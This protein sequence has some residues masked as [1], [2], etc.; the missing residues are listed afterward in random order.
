MRYR[1]TA[2]GL[3]V[4]DRAP[5]RGVLGARRWFTPGGGG[6]GGSPVNVTRF[7]SGQLSLSGGSVDYTIGSVSAGDLVLVGVQGFLNVSTATPTVTADG[8]GNTATA[9]VTV[10]Q[11]FIDATYGSADIVELAI[12]GGGTLVVKLSQGGGESAV[13]IVGTQWGGATYTYDTGGV[14]SPNG[15]TQGNFLD[16]Y[17][18]SLTIA[19]NRLVM[20][21][22]GGGGVVAVSSG[23]ATPD[24]GW[25]S[26]AG[27]GAAVPLTVVDKLVST[28]TQPHVVYGSFAY[29]CGLC[30]AYSY[31]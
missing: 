16:M 6:G 20:A 29:G 2:S 12:T 24:A 30:V 3:W 4:P 1:R 5:R 23:A 18:A 10:R 26:Q 31:T 17:S 9:T 13:F 7:G 21:Y 27:T 22:F 28:N 11:S 19:A 15:G 8:T 14:G 25:G